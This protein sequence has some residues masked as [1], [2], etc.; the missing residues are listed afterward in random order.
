MVAIAEDSAP[1]PKDAIHTT[2]DTNLQSSCAPPEPLLVG[3]FDHEV[4][5]IP[6]NGKMKDTKSS[7]RSLC[8]AI[9]DS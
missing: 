1:A 9:P 4:N 6:L 2:R 8:D 3:G 7:A 5:V